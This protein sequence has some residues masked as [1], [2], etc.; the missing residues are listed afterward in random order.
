MHHMWAIAVQDIKRQWTGS[1]RTSK[2]TRTLNGHNFSS[3]GPITLTFTEAFHADDVLK[4]KDV[5]SIFGRQNIPM[6]GLFPTIG[7]YGPFQI[8]D[9]SIPSIRAP[10]QLSENQK[11]NGI[12]LL[13]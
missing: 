10:S 5:K 3:V 13:A 4:S 8:W 12:P 1:I 6:H 9:L 7:N 2:M 11:I